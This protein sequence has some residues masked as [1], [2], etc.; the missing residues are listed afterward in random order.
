MQHVSAGKQQSAAMLYRGRVWGTSHA[1][2][3]N[4][5]CASAHLFLS[6]SASASV[7]PR[8]IALALRAATLSRAVVRGEN[9]IVRSRRE[10]TMMEFRFY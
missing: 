8:L 3:A 1:P 9:S 2:S 4:S 6:R 7:I 5:S 10:P